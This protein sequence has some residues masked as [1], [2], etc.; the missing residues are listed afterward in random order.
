MKM[1]MQSGDNIHMM[2]SG[3]RDFM[4]DLCN[5]DVI[6]GS[7]NPD[8]QRIVN[9]HVLNGPRT[10]RVITLPVDTIM[11]VDWSGVGE[12]QAPNFELMSLSVDDALVGSAR[13]PGNGQG[14]PP[15]GPVVSDP[16]PPQQVLLTAGEQTLF[17]D[18]LYRRHYQRRPL[19]LRKGVLPV[20]ADV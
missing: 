19:P 20:R 3:D 10:T 2:A 7:D 8:K 9:T 5:Y 4:L 15:M 11:T 12:T 13:A 1:P 16:P 6:L 18:A 17:A 14:C